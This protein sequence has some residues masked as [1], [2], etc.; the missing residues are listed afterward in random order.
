MLQDERFKAVFED[1]DY[2]INK[3]SENY[4]LLKPTLGKKDYD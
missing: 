2:A 1:K 3:E 4:R